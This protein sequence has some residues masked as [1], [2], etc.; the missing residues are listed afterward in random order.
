MLNENIAAAV[1]T[2]GLAMHTG[3]YRSDTDFK[4]VMIVWA[5]PGRSSGL[6]VFFVPSKSSV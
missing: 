3:D 2:S 5:S 4:A 1:Q 6:S